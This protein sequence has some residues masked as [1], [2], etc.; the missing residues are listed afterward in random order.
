VV[1]VV[2]VAAASGGARSRSNSLYECLR[3]SGC[4]CYVHISIHR[5]TGEGVSGGSNFQKLRRRSTSVCGHIGVGCSCRPL[6]FCWFSTITCEG[7]LGGQ[8]S[9]AH[10]V[11]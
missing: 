3:T 8:D 6:G 2:V 5:Q 10:K 1:V 11:T 7:R 4:Q 9:S